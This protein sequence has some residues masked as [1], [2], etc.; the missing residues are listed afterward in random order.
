[1]SGQASDLGTSSY[2]RPR[3]QCATSLPVK[4]SDICFDFRNFMI[5]GQL[6]LSL[7]ESDYDRS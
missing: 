3:D 4:N 2:P 5:Q 7:P 1:M 6:V